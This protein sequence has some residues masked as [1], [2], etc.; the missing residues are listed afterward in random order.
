MGLRNVSTVFVHCG[1][2]EIEYQLFGLVVVV[3]L[4][5]PCAVFGMVITV[6]QSIVYVMTGIYGPPSELGPGI[7]LVIVIQVGPL[8]GPFTSCSPECLTSCL[9]CL[10]AVCWF[11]GAAVG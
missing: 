10:V 9:H 5:L 11:G 2:C 7:C 6:G 1:V 4:S 8:C 3:A